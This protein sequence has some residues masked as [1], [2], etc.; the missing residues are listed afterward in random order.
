MAVAAGE[1]DVVAAVESCHSSGLIVGNI[2]DIMLFKF[3]FIKKTVIDGNLM[4]L[5]HFK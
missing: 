2:E 4:R 5:H 3:A 1:A